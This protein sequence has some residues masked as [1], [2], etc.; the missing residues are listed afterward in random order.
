MTTERDMLDA[1]HQRYSVTSQSNT[2]RY[3]VAEFVRNRAG[4]EATNTADFIAMDLWPRYGM[5]LEL[6]G[7]EVKVSRRDW[8][9][10]LR[11]PWK[12]AA[13]RPYMNR[14]WLVVPDASIVKPGELPEGWGLMS[15]RGGR[16]QAV[17]AAPAVEA[18]PMPKTMMA[19]LLRS[20]QVTAMRRIER[21]R[22]PA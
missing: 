16:L 9:V 4:F 2:I 17:T 19:A 1:L 7:H 13:F 5:G 20:T 10:E 11:Q 3:S 15:L 8:L 14:W 18:E 21:L 22:V 6:H 12:S